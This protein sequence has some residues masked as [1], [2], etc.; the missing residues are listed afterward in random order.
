MIRRRPSVRGAEVVPSS[1][2][3]NE[4]RRQLR[5]LLL[6]PTLVVGVGVVALGL[7]VA[8][9]LAQQSFGPRSSA[10]VALI[11]FGGMLGIFLLRRWAERHVARPAMRDDPS[12]E[13]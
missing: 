10:A 6:N 12:D 4:Q 5:D 2:E 1:P 8:P 7:V 9:I 13:A 11:L 3:D